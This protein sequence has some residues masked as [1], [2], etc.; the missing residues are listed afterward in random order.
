MG[1]RLRRAALDF[2]P[3]CVCTCVCPCTRPSAPAA[4]LPAWLPLL[5]GPIG[6][7]GLRGEVGLPGIKGKLGR[8]LGGK[9]VAPC[10]CLSLIGG[11]LGGRE[12]L[13]VMG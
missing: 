2:A 8:G 4:H 1:R 13:V 3:G 9:G 7:Q 6:P 12:G 5:A 10:R 11:G